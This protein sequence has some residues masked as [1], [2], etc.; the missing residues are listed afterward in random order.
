MHPRGML[1]KDNIRYIYRT[2]QV[3]KIE[4]IIWLDIILLLQLAPV[5]KGLKW[6]GFLVSE[7][8]LGIKITLAELES[9]MARAVTSVAEEDNNITWADKWMMIFVGQ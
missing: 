6:R 2:I 5:E 9:T 8:N 3:K 1:L 4:T 7:A